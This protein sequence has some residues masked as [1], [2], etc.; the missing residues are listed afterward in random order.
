MPFEQCRAQVVAQRTPD[1]QG[2][3]K[4]LFFKNRPDFGDWEFRVGIVI[5]LESHGIGDDGIDF[6]H[7][8]RLNGFWNR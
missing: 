5:P 7:E 2:E 3:G 4:I 8:K 6:M 1:W